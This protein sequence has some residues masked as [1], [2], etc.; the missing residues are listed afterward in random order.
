MATSN[1]LLEA[2]LDAIGPGRTTDPPKK[3]KT[4]KGIAGRLWGVATGLAG[5]AQAPL[6]LAKDIALA[7][8]TDDEY[9]GL[10]DTLWRAPLHRLVG[11]PF[12]NLAGPD[13]GFGAAVGA[14]PQPVRERV[15]NTIEGAAAGAL[16]GAGAGSF[17]AG[18][19][20]IPGAAAGAIGGAAYGATTNRSAFEDLE[21][22]YREGVA[23]PLSTAFT[24]QALHDAGA[25]DLLDFGT[26]GEAYRVAQDRSLGQS[27]ALM[28]S[29]TDITDENELAR[30]VGSDFYKIA[31]GVTDAIARLAFQ[32]E[33][34]AGKAAVGYRAGRSLFINSADDINR[35]A[36]APGFQAWIDELDG[37]SAAEIRDRFF[38]HHAQGSAIA[39]AL[40]F[41]TDP[42]ARR[43][44]ARALMGDRAAKDALLIDRPAL[45]GRISRLTE[46]K[47]KLHEY[48]GGTLFDNPARLADVEAELK[49]LYP[50][51]RR[52]A[53][54]D[55]LTDKAPVGVVPN[56]STGKLRTTLK[57][58]D[59]YQ[60]S[61]YAAPLRA[62]FEMVP[63]R[64]VN[65]HDPT[66]DVQLARN[67]EAS[68]LPQEVQ[69]Q[70][71][72]RYMA[73]NGPTDR[74]KVMVEAEDAAVRKIAADAGMT[75]D[76]IE[77]LVAQAAT[78]RKNAGMV[79][80]SR[81][82]DGKGRSKVKFVDDDGVT[83]EIN[84]PAFI[85]QEVNV[86][87]L[88]DINKVRKVATRVGR[89]RARHPGADIPKELMGDFYR[90]WKPSVL[91]RAGWPL[92]I[93]ADEQL[94]IMA[95]IGAAAQMK[96]LRYAPGVKQAGN[97]I[98]KKKVTKV[99]EDGFKFLDYEIQAAYGN[100]GDAANLYR[101]MNS[102]SSSFDELIG[103]NEAGILSRLRERTG[104]YEGS[105]TPDAP[106]YGEAWAH[107]VN[108]QFG[109]DIIGK[110]ILSGEST[111]DT[112]RWLTSTPEGQEAAMRFHFRAGDDPTEWVEVMTQIID[113][114]TG[115]SP[116]L[117]RLARDGIA[118]PEHLIREIPDA[119]NRPLVHGEIVA[120][121]TGSGVV[122]QWAKNFVESGMRIL[123]QTPTD[124]LAR[125]PF[126]D[127]M[128]RAEVTRLV[129]IA[130]EQMPGLIQPKQLRLMEQ[131]AREY[132]LRESKELLYDLAEESRLSE[133]LSF[134]MPF[135]SAWQEVMTRW[136]GLAVENPAFVG[137]LRQGW[138]APER[139]HITVD[140]RGWELNEK[141]TLARHPTSGQWVKPK[142]ETSVVFRVPKWAQR[143]IPGLKSV[144]EMAFRKD[145]ANL[146]LQGGPGFGPPIQML[147][148]E[149]AKNR[150]DL[151]D[152]LKF[153]LPFGVSD[154]WTDMLMPSTAKRAYALAE[155]D[156][157][158]QYANAKKRI[159]LT[160]ITRYELG[161]RDTRP[162][163]QEATKRADD[164][165]KMRTFV[166]WTSPVAMQFNS[167]FQMQIE[168]YRSAMERL[169]EDEYALGQRPDGS[170]VSADEWFLDTYGEEYFAL[171]QSFSR[172]ND[173]IPPTKEG[174]AARKKYRDLIEQ[175]PELGGLIIGNEGAG[176]YSNFVYESQAS[177]TIRPTSGV[178][179]RSFPDYE[180]TEAAPN[181]RLGWIKY[182]RYMDLID[183]ERVQRGLPSLNVKAARD[184]RDLKQ[185]I[186][187]ALEEKYPEWAEERA[188]MDGK[189]FERRLEGMRAI[190]S[191]RRMAGRDEFEGL[192]EYL[193]YRDMVIAELANRPA[194]TLTA[195]ANM[196][197]ADTWEAIKAAL[198]EKN[199]SFGSLYYRYLENDPMEVG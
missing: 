111:E 66:S 167:P 73:A 127:H 162:S 198:V 30:A 15:G 8:F 46:E 5:A 94:R 12:E 142:G 156:D 170:P 133:M 37:L 91:L 190:V 81:S 106:N 134:Y 117:R 182:G 112:V 65:L 17:G 126:F 129:K 121:L 60:E 26:W 50:E 93:A 163:W 79:V 52:L 86:H 138:M 119:A 49:D 71:R 78:G 187:A 103:K 61:I 99:G 178:K 16:V 34:A 107:A 155:G 90:I 194:T 22:I 199:L 173:G 87:T 188:Q 76:E 43:T 38:P 159:F 116:I 169:R 110:R 143:N 62:T 102:S 186:T 123:G 10:V 36:A 59:F 184:L 20:A 64:W 132:A 189:S 150:P 174:L 2:T 185:Q 101:A 92:R 157:N 165:W 58:S 75:V 82:Y 114:Y 109:K 33:I 32:P 191:D 160:E 1:E 96:Y 141:G 105:I 183:V 192:S 113:D 67:L 41:E 180:E 24:A 45:A 172:S 146:L 9:G 18:I 144:G 145:S 55:I 158:R 125:N 42:L 74:L 196:D 84:L 128:Y 147:A 13:E 154:S 148:N 27:F 124:V 130:D 63:N 88:V 21:T 98:A 175:Y 23:E 137:R 135:Y 152:S 40:A 97:A 54:L 193:R 89:F 19:A 35:V 149:I 47:S 56:A 7:P 57:R 104:Q 118:T 140:E 164:F 72:N 131:A 168:A 181:V 115:G 197:L 80:K 4:P 69:D 179:Q 53:R 171:T 85:T 177:N 153:V 195:A 70:F 166:S 48:A 29:G 51:A 44:V 151:E 11:Q 122:M 139:M 176:E 6:G 31:S 14:L 28:V 161:E 120:Q 68:T 77:G 108:N 100:R 83:H 136:A 3:R 39:D 95:K 25:G